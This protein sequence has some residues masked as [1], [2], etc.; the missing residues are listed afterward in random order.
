[1]S[2]LKVPV[3]QEHIRLQKQDSKLNRVYEVYPTGKVIALSTCINLFA[4]IALLP[5]PVELEQ[6]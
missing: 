4:F 5:V 2:H 1:M 6:M 3:Y